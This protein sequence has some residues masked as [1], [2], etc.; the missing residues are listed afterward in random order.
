M[1]SLSIPTEAPVHT[2]L[3]TSAYTQRPNKPPDKRR[4]ARLPHMYYEPP[5]MSVSATP[6]RTRPVNTRCLLRACHST[7]PNQK[8][9][10][11]SDRDV[12]RDRS[13]HK[14]GDSMRTRTELQAN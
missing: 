13:L 2:I 5:A 7:K 11:D 12:E 4:I 8:R 6:S 9:K 14:M 1:T 10:R 3:F